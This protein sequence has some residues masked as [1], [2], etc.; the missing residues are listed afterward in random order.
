MQSRKYRINNRT[1]IFWIFSLCAACDRGAPSPVIDAGADLAAA[2][3]ATGGRWRSHAPLPI[4]RQETAVVALAD[5]IVV[6]GG[7]N[8]N[9]DIVANVDTYDPTADHWTAVS[10]LPEPLHH[11]NAAV[12]N[13]RVY[14]LGASSGLDFAAV[15]RGYVYDPAQDKWSPVR[16][17]PAGTERG[18][19]AVAVLDGRIHVAGGL[20]GG[21]AVAD[22]AVYD[23]GSDTW[24]ALPPLPE[25]RE[26][27]VGAA[28][29][30]AFLAIGGRS[31]TITS[32][33]GRVDAYDPAQKTW[34]ARA[35]LPTPRGG[36]ACAVLDG[37]VYVIGGEGNSASPRGVFANNEVYDPSS[38]TWSVAE[39]MRTPRHGTGA[40]AL[41]GR[42][43]VPGGADRQ[44]FGAV[45]V[46]ESFAP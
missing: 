4:A 23:P 32:L 8:A 5:R 19:A 43:F 24:T 39:P 28:A 40:A 11:A 12:V 29:G 25:G 34:T 20:R 37:R 14:V 1:I 44:A 41:A 26:H 9:A 35:P 18:S 27:L 38:D 33:R 15:G 36:A 30:G 31:A 22:H 17:M 13:E 7:F 2:D 3:L 16:A 21:Q 6:I 45:A 10:P 42:V 46:V